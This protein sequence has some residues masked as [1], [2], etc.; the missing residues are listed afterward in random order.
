AAYKLRRP[1][2]V[3]LDRKTD[4]IMAGGRHPM[5]IDYTVGF[6]SD[7]KIT[8]LNVDI[9]INAGISTDISPIMPWNMVGAL[10]KYNWG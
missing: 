5:K 7:G 8:A 9:L 3:Y 4:M 2:R 10:K 6:K 1:V